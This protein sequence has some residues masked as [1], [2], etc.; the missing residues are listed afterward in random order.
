MARSS[1]TVRKVADHAGVSIATVSRVTRRPGLVASETRERVERAISELGYRPSHFGQALV[2]RRHSAI[3]VVFPGLSGPYYY[4]VI[5]GFEAEAIAARLS[6]LIL[7]THHVRNDEQV[8]DMATRVD[9]IAILGGTAKDETIRTLD[10]QGMPLALLAQHPVDEVPAVRIDNFTAMENLTGHLLDAHDLHSIAFL[11]DPTNSPDLT[12]RWNGFVAAHCG[13]GLKP[14]GGP[15]KIVLDQP[16]GL[17]AVSNLLAGPNA[18]RAIVCANDEIALGAYAAA[19]AAGVRIPD[20]LA[21][22]GFDDIPM[23]GLLSPGLTT[24]AQPMRELGAR[25]ARL[26]LAQIRG[27]PPGTPDVILPTRLLIRGSCGCRDGP[28]P[29]T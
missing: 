20:D 10:H 11:G 7:G 23:A 26:L 4:D 13:R 8:L 19:A 5:Q 6:V 27:D 29:T 24:V 22:T 28:D 25:V 2:D 9:G 21:L 1:P 3:G 14:P 18:P 12:D 16:S 15:I 17:R